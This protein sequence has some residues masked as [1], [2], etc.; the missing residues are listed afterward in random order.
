MMSRLYLMNSVVLPPG[1]F[2]KFEY[3]PAIQADLEDV[4]KGR[5]GPWRCRIGYEQNV[6]LIRSWTGVEVPLNRAETW[7][8][9]GDRAVV[10]RLAKRLLNPSTK[11]E[12]VEEPEWEFGWVKRIA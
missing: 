11:G 4:V 5:Y 12:T 8:D 7:F 6:Q 1:N 3:T 10:M 2:G 9:V